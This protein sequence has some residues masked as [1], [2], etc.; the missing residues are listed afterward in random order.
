M[1]STTSTLMFFLSHCCAEPNPKARNS[2][3]STYSLHRQVC[4]LSVFTITIIITSFHLISIKYRAVFAKFS[5][6]L[7]SS[8]NFVTDTRTAQAFAP[9]GAKLWS[10]PAFAFVTG[11]ITTWTLLNDNDQ[12]IWSTIVVILHPLTDQPG[13]HLHIPWHWHLPCPEQTIPLEP[14]GQLKSSHSQ[15]VPQIVPSL[16]GGLKQWQIPHWQVPRPEH[17]SNWLLG[18][19]HLFE[20]DSGSA[21]AR[22]QEQP[23]PEYPALHWQIPHLYSPT[24]LHL[25]SF[26][27]PNKNT[28]N[29]FI[30]KCINICL[31][32]SCLCRKGIDTGFA[33]RLLEYR[34]SQPDEN[35]LFRWNFGLSDM[36]S[37]S[38]LRRT[39]LPIPFL[40]LCTFGSPSVPH[41]DKT[42]STWQQPILKRCES[43]VRLN[44]V[45]AQKG[46]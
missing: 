29:K 5:F 22:L 39:R 41:S 44:L 35:E 11:T 26:Y 34:W 10:W 3:Q 13:E 20:L 12:L 17:S 45:S 21:V 8:L 31:P 32:D 15:W 30:N 33:G 14:R 43:F 19:L 7:A 27:L 4:G 18:D 2:T 1:L 25:A 23:I 40:A 16:L 6:V 42:R 28:W 38:I 37:R 46:I 24:P 36:R 9:T